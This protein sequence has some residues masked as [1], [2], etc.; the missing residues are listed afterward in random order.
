MRVIPYIW[1]HLRGRA[2]RSVALLLGVLVATSG[3]TVLT[4]ATDTARLAVPGGV[5]RSATATYQV[6][7]RPKGSRTRLEDDRQ[8]V[9]PNSLSGIY[10]GIT[11]DQAARTPG[12]DGVHR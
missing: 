6:L 1:A 3:F 10:G 11:A 12:L 7:V 2:A 4:G 8:K 5:N 9:R